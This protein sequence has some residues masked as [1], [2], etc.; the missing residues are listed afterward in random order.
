MEGSIMEVRL[1]TTIFDR[2]RGLKAYKGYRGALMLAPCHDVHTFGMPTSLDIAFVARDGTVLVALR[3]VPPLRRRCCRGA[4]MTLE[5]YA[6]DEAWVSVGDV[7]HIDFNKSKM[8]MRLKKGCSDE[9]V[10]CLSSESV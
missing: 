2:L 10:S 4:A 5:R 6:S 9:S 1:A 3:R 7:L 8:S